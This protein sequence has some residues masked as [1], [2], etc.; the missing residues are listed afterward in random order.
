MIL[1]LESQKQYCE[2]QKQDGFGYVHCM[3]NS[4]RTKLALHLI[5]CEK[6]NWCQVHVTKIDFK[7]MS[8]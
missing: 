8:S 1:K 2:L 6:I 4:I 7:H 3:R 5:N